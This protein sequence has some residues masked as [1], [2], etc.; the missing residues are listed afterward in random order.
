MSMESIRQYVLA[1]K[2]IQDTP[3]AIR[4]CERFLEVAQEFETIKWGLSMEFART[5][6]CE[7]QLCFENCQRIA[8]RSPGLRYFEGFVSYGAI[9][10]EH[11]WLVDESGE[12]ID[13]TLV[14][15]A[16]LRERVEGYMGLAIPSDYLEGLYLEDARRD[17]RIEQAFADGRW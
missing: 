9:V 4:F 12:V 16:K 13:P 17:S 6:D 11:A 8:G 7:E 3:G 15:H 10:A 5:Y 2:D 1:I 14:L